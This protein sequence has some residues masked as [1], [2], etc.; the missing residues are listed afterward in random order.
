M[1]RAARARE[2]RRS[3][4]NFE[5]TDKMKAAGSAK[6]RNVVRQWRMTRRSGA[7]VKRRV[8]RSKSGTGGGGGGGGDGAKTFFWSRD[9]ESVV[10]RFTKRDPFDFKRRIVCVCVC[11]CVFVAG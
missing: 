3:G 1:R 2:N 8:R 4:E 10:R 11:V 7:G 9:A 6:K 5:G